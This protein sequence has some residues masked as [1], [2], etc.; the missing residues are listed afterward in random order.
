MDVPRSY[1]D[2]FTR[3]I[4]SISEA[5]QEA[6]RQELAAVDYSD[7][8]R[9]I[10]RI[11]N[12]MQF[13][14]SVSAESAAQLAAEFYRG[15]SMLQ[16]GEDYAAEPFPSHVDAAT[17]E[18]TR[19][20]AQ[21]AVNGNI[22]A[23]AEQLAQ[24]VDYEAKRAAGDT[25][26]QNAFVDPRDVKFARIPAGSE[27]CPFCIALSSRGFVYSSAEAAGIN[28]HYHANC[29]CRI[30][31]SWD[32]SAF[33]G[34]DPD[35]LYEE[36]LGW[37]RNLSGSRAGRSII[38]LGDTDLSSAADVIRFINAATSFNNLRRR[39]EVLN[40]Q[41]PYQDYSDADK[42]RMRQALYRKRDQFLNS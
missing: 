4:N 12:L 30:V 13:V 26:M 42:E 3:G 2:N 10:D 37:G 24:R 6:L 16:T 21:E 5:S 17:E 20:M 11:V 14:C 40:A 35:A 9:A 31:P 29:D 34:Y 18:A 27:T 38:E 22:A 1:I 32:D 28:G 41:S 8:T 23:M 7:M 15:M 25:V 19:A 36:Y 33:E 39:V